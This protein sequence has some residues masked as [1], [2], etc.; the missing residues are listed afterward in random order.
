MPAV[1]QCGE[2]ANA[3]DTREI[4]RGKGKLEGG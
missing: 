2:A 4:R 1:G 3:S